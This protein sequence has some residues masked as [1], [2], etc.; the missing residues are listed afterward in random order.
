[1]RTLYLIME[2]HI[3]NIVFHYVS[4]GIVNASIKAEKIAIR[5]RAVPF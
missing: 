2:K 4:G 5:N 3:N 1:M